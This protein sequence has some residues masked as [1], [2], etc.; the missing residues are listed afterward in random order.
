MNQPAIFARSQTVETAAGPVEIGE[1]RVRDLPRAIPIVDRLIP[2][3]LAAAGE[4]G[5]DVGPEEVADLV[6]QGGDDLHAAIGVFAGREETWS[7]DLTLL[8]LVNVVT[9][10]VTVNRDFFSQRL[11]RM[12]RRQPEP[13]VEPEASTEPSTPGLSPA[14]AS[15]EADTGSATS[16]ATP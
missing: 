14:S 5:E 10:I 3:Y 8:D 15:S 11:A 6:V 2:L 4:R 1:L 16:S 7:Q 12:V 13:T 9:A